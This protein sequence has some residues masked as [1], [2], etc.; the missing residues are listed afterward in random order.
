[1]GLLGVMFYI[2]WRFTLI[3]LSVAP[4][5]FLVIHKKEGEMVSI[6]QEVL[7][8]IRVVKTF[9]REDYEQHHLEEESL[10]TVE[11]GLRA[12]SL[13]AKLVAIG[14]NHRSNS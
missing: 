7:G 10:E 3:V 9:A 4:I 14:R 1:V 2:N 8:S 12:R 11:T 5:L 13:K 6:I